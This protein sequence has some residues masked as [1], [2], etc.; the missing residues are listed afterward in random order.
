MVFKIWMW[1][2][3]MVCSLTVNVE[4]LKSM[5]KTEATVVLNILDKRALR[6]QTFTCRLLVYIYFIFS[7]SEL[8]VACFCF[9]SRTSS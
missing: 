7:R 2:L 4:V 5:V 8:I 3:V 6:R 1:H 9:F